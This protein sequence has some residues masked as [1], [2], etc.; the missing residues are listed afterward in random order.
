M[1]LHCICGDS[2][3]P[4]IDCE[5]CRFIRERNVLVRYTNKLEQLVS[6][7][8]RR[9]AD[10]HSIWFNDCGEGDPCTWCEDAARALARGVTP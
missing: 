8:V 6:E 5:R 4:D 3:D 9:H 1:G 10:P 7:N 2:A